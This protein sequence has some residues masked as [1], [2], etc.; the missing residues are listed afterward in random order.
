VPAFVDFV[1]V[2]HKLS[3]AIPAGIIA[4][5]P[6]LAT[7]LHLEA[8]SFLRSPAIALHPVGMGEVEAIG[9]IRRGVDPM[10]FDL[11]RDPV[12]PGYAGPQPG[13]PAD[14]DAYHSR[15]NYANGRMMKSLLAD[16]SSKIP[17]NP[18]HEEELR[19]EDEIDE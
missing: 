9:L 16:L 17:A 7:P 3:S 6:I 2:T 8:Y 18:V 4:R 10:T 12:L 5:V 15:I 19:A 14:W 13:T 1:Y 11:S